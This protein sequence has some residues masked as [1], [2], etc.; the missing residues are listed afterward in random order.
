MHRHPSFEGDT[1]D[2]EDLDS[3]FTV[4]SNLEKPTQ[5]K[6][7]DETNPHPA[8]IRRMILAG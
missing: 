7:F 8:V 3:L 5:A 2:I 6:R 4:P 1:A